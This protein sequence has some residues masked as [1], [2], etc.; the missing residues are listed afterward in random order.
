MLTEMIGHV[1]YARWSCYTANRMNGVLNL[2]VRVLY[3]GN[4]DNC[5]IR[6]V[7]ANKNVSASWRSDGAIK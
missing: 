5:P 4:E 7:I 3:V 1:S 2:A 6:R